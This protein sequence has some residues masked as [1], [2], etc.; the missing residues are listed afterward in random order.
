MKCIDKKRIISSV[1]VI[2]M[3]ISACGCAKQ[4]EESATF[5]TYETTNYNTTLFTTTFFAE[6]LAVTSVDTSSVSYEAPVDNI[7]GAGLFGV[8]SEEVYYGYN[9]FETLYPASTTKIITAYVALKYGNLDDVVTITAEDV[10]LP[11]DSS[12]CGLSEGDQL[13]L[14]DLLVGLLL[15]S[16]N[17]NAM[18]IARH[19]SGDVDTFAAL[20]TSEAAALG[21]TGS[22]FVNPHGLHDENHY[23]T[24]Y[25]LYL[26]FNECIKNQDFIDIISISSYSTVITSASGEETSITWSPTN[27]Y[28]VGTQETPDN[29]DLIGGK[30]GY[31]DNARSCLVLLEQDGDENQYISIVLGAASKDT[32]YSQM[33]ELIESLPTTE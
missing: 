25:D 5:S 17:D 18:A 29:V 26:I 27:A 7:Y 16:G 13:T 23:T 22:N 28:A 30:T 19:I 9:L 10:D 3:I 14:Y 15:E 20:M 31:T 33:T 12:V 24:V 21:A 11:W 4:E 1:L 8:D 6:D 2:S 32:L